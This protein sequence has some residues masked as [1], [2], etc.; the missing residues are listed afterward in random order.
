MGTARERGAETSG[1]IVV[2]PLVCFGRL[3][4]RAPTSPADGDGGPIVVFLGHINVMI[5]LMNLAPVAGF[6]GKT[7]W[8]VLPGLVRWL[9]GRAMVR[10]AIRR[11]SKRE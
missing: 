4:C 11:A 6:D 1:T 7:A 2:P 10:K 8:R 5:A 3:I 9:R